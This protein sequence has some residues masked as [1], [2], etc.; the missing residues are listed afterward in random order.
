MWSKGQIVS[1]QSKGSCL[2]VKTVC[3]VKHS[4]AWSS[5]LQAGKMAAGNLDIAAGI[6]FT[7]NTYGRVSDLSNLLHIAMIG[8]T[9]FH[10][11]QKRILFPVINKHYE[12]SK[13]SIFSYMKT[14]DTVD[15][16]GDG[17]CDSPGYNAKYGTYTFM[18]LP[19]NQIVNFKVTHVSQVANSNVLEKYGFLQALEEIEN[20][21]PVTSIT[22]DRH[23]QIK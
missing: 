17:R 9:L 4:C 12:L 14:L 18:L 11:L 22:T 13:P 5:Q 19:S 3:P 21:L 16:A 8:K 20:E 23:V 7:G 10:R 2:Y 6:L 1:A 15:L